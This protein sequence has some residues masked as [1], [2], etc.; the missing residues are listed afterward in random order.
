MAK[1][2]VAFK[3]TGFDR[4]MIVMTRL[5]SLYNHPSFDGIENFHPPLQHTEDIKSTAA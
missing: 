3:Q 2:Q 4:D 1:N 5:S